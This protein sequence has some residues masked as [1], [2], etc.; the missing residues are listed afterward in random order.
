MRRARATQGQRVTVRRDRREAGSEG[1]GRVFDGVEADP[2]A[3]SG[4]IPDRVRVRRSVG[5]AA[6]GMAHLVLVRERAA[7]PDDERASR[8]FSRT[9]HEVAPGAT[10]NLGLLLWEP[11]R[12]IEEFD[13]NPWEHIGPEPF[14]DE[15]P[16]A[17]LSAPRP[18]RSVDHQ[19]AHPLA[20]GG[21]AFHRPAGRGARRS[22]GQRR[23]PG[24]TTGTASPRRHGRRRKKA[25]AAI[26]VSRPIARSGRSPI[27]AST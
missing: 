18:P 8:K 10:R 13:A 16:P 7:P 1:L 24:C 9:R 17:H 4:T 21:L 22:L 15:G 23:R 20:R 25:G 5:V 26:R 19:R 3:V 14:R 27:N 12:R 11:R 6:R 2:S